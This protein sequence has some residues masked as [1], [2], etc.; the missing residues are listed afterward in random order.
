MDIMVY[1]IVLRCAHI[2]QYENG[3][4]KKRGQREKKTVNDTKARS[5]YGYINNVRMKYDLLSILPSGSLLQ[6][7]R[8]R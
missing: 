4:E 1:D 2:R 3:G 7:W 5:S 8:R 6:I